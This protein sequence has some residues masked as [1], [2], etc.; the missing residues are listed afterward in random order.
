M[1][2]VYVCSSSSVHLTQKSCNQ[3]IN[4]SA[5]KHKGMQFLAPHRSSIP[6]TS[7]HALNK[8]Q[9]F[10]NTQ[11]KKKEHTYNFHVLFHPTNPTTHDKMW[12]WNT[13]EPQPEVETTPKNLICPLNRRLF[14]SKTT[15]PSLSPVSCLLSL[16]HLH[17]YIPPP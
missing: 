2:V 5:H 17:T 14:M 1:Y 11:T 6:P 8:I 9:K 7:S 13:R 12:I 4:L 10:K 15:R 16:L 3:R